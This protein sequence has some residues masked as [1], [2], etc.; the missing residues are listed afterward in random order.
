MELVLRIPTPDEEE[1]F[2]RAHRATSPDAPNFLHGYDD[3]MP[4]GRYLEMLVEQARG[5]QLP[6]GYVASTFLFAF[7]GPRIVGRV[8]IRH[9]LNSVPRKHSADTSVTW[10]CQSSDDRGV[11]TEMLRQALVIARER[12]A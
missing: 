3:G 6:P 11:A 9:T 1:E 12:S 8:S 4:F 5:E 2:L 7:A 10:W